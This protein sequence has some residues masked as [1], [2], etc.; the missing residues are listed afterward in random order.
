[1]LI[2]LVHAGFK[3]YDISYVGENIGLAYISSNLQ[4]HGYSTRILDC[5]A[6]GWDEETLLQE[7]TTNNPAI[8]MFS[9]Y[10]ENGK[11]TIAF[12]NMLRMANYKSPILLGGI[13]ATLN[14]KTVLNSLADPTKVW[15]VRGEGEEVSV[16]FA[17]E[18]EH[19]ST[20]PSIKGVAYKSKEEIINDDFVNMVCD[21]DSLPFP[22]RSVMDRIYGKLNAPIYLLSSRGCYGNCSFCIL[23]IY[24]SKFAEHDRQKKWRER[25]ISSVVNEMEELSIRYPGAL[26]KFVDSNFIGWNP[27]RGLVLADEIKQRNL[28]VKFA[29]ECRANDINEN[30]LLALKEVGLT[31]V[32]I[33][34]ES[35]SNRVLK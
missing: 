31:S 18:I 20:E 15:C 7:I 14:T 28:K 6:D 25:T 12:I 35:G 10:E 21:I 13:Y 8:V 27:Q 17:R 11:E 23:N 4:N 30:I 33:G 34:V 16:K 22:D 1:M 2:Y 9:F 26:I 3:T 19:G 24:N 5:L 32:F 29:I